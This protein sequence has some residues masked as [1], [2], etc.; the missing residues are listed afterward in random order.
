MGVM[1]GADG[2]GTLVATYLFSIFLITFGWRSGSLIGCL[3]FLIILFIA[4]KYLKDPPNFSKTIEVETLKKNNG[5]KSNIPLLIN[6]NVIGSSIYVIA[7][8][9]AFSLAVYWVPTILIEESGWSEGLAGFIGASFAVAG[10]LGAIA[11]GFFSDKLG[12]RALLINVAGVGL[13]VMFFGFTY[14]YVIGNY[15]LLAI[16]LPLAGLF[17]YAGMPVAY[18]LVADTVDQ[19]KIGFVNGIVICLGFTIGGLVVPLLI[20][21]VKDTTDSYSI[22]FVA[23]TIYLFVSILI[24]MF[25]LKD[26]VNTNKEHT[27][28]K[29][30]ASFT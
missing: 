19:S 9:S 24:N 27:S 15:T 8:I 26:R 1:L 7:Q 23:L 28:S 14:S 18:A 12:K 17:A 2:V 16:L 25:L 21:Y 20:G 5:F 22:G 11:A 13:L 30:A 3:P 4:L 6:R 29:E 10:T